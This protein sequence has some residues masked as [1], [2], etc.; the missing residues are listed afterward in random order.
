M[1]N[2][3]LTFLE[4]IRQAVHASDKLVYIAGEHANALRLREGGMGVRAQSV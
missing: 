4:E 2:R 3:G 1:P